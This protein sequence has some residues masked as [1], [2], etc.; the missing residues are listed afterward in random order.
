MPRKSNIRWSESD[1]K[2]L[3]R[4][5]R[6]Y[7]AKINRERKKLISQDKRYQAAQLPK[8]ASVKEL[9]ESI[10]TRSDYNKELSRMQNYIDTGLKFVLDKNTEKSLNATVSDYNIKIRKLQKKAKTA[11]ERAALPELINKE[12]LLKE[13]PSKEALIADLKSYKGFLK[14]GAEEIVALKDNGENKFNIK[15][16]KWQKS[17]MDERLKIVNENRAK[18][19]EAWKE[20][21]VKYGGKKAGYKHGA[22]RMDDGDFDG[23]GEMELYTYSTNYN[24]LRKKV[25]LIMRES[26]DGY[27]ESRTELARI[28]YIETMDKL[29]GHHPA[30]KKLIQHIKSMPLSDFKRTL[31]S[32]DDLWLT[33]YKAQYHPEDFEMAVEEV[34]NQWREDAMPTA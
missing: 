16:T 8:T 33:L 22:A 15:M 6:N 21:D 30:G 27:W 26:K 10:E 13:A 5:T 20:T 19:L 14:P 11:G 24:D 29:M 31:K 34:W 25:K 28:N 7:N 17:L 23:L 4:I 2:E 1:Q 32:E 18:E 12:R 9:R 3:R